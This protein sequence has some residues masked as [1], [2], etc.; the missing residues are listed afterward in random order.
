MTL[1][2]RGVEVTLRP[3]FLD[4]IEALCQPHRRMNLIEP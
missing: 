4:D 2:L 1:V 3:L